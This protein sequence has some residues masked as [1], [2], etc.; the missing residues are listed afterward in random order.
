MPTGCFA[1]LSQVLPTVEEL[2][3]WVRV[4]FLSLWGVSGFCYVCAGCWNPGVPAKPA[5]MEADENAP[6]LADAEPPL[7][8]PGQEYTLSRDSNRYVKGFDHYCEFVG[9]DIGRGNMYCFVC[10]LAVLAFLSTFVVVRLPR[11]CPFAQ[12]RH[13]PR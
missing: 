11:P 5:P 1:R 8:H 13:L 10:F 9:N 2:G 12:R 7:Q 4:A 3:P 6:H